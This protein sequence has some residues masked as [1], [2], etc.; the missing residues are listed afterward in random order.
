MLT[1]RGA[2]ITRQQEEL[3]Q[4]RSSLLQLASILVAGDAEHETVIKTA[5]S[6]AVA[7]ISLGYSS[8]TA[9]QMLD[10]MR[11]WLRF[12]VDSFPRKRAQEEMFLALDSMLESS[13]PKKQHR[14]LVWDF[15]SAVRRP[16]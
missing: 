11:S 1:Q 12:P 5:Q 9:L 15:Q 6:A 4:A 2:Q 16:D 7:V 13:L 10:T 8:T 3:R 14:S